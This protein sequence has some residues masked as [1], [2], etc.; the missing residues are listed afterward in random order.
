MNGHQWGCRP[1]SMSSS[2]FTQPLELRVH[3]RVC[4]PSFYHE[5]WG[6]SRWLMGLIPTCTTCSRHN[7]QNWYY[8]DNCIM[9]PVKS[10]GFEMWAC[11]PSRYKPH[12]PWR[13][14]T[15]FKVKFISNLHSFEGNHR[16]FS[17]FPT[18]VEWKRHRAAQQTLIPNVWVDFCS[19][20]STD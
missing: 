16:T 7:N 2:Y 8:S 17:P 14:S 20:R 1:V 3:G 18:P 5:G 12:Q 13:I 19:L 15:S 11:R 4:V 10:T 9:G 6:G